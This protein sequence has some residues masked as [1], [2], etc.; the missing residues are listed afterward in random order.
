[1][2]GVT[3]ELVVIGDDEGEGGA[4]GEDLLEGFEPGEDLLVFE[5]P[6]DLDG[7]EGMAC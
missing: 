6:Q 7:V 4:D 5:L 1:M 3:F 2:E